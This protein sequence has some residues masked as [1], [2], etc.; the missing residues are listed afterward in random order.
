MPDTAC[1]AAPPFSGAPCRGALSCTY[2][3][4]EGPGQFDCEGDRWNG[5]IMCLGCPPQLVEE[6]RTPFTGSAPASVQMGPAEGAFRP[7][8]PGERVP[9]IWGGQGLPMVSFRLRVGGETPPSCAR[10]VARTSLDGGTAAVADR[11]I[12]TRC[13]ETL[14]ILQIV[15]GDP[16]LMRDYSLQVV[17]DVVGVGTTSADLV[18]TG[19]MCPRGG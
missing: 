19:G 5:G 6:C 16:C 18:I 4:P 3:T 9:V 11:A 13:G 7:F 14:T 2:T 10:V 15:P 17:V 8:D 1:P 12:V